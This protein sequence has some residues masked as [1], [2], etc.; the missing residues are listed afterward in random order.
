MN[1]PKLNVAIL[2]G[3]RSSEHDISRLSAAAVI[4]ALDPERYSAVPV[5]IERSGDWRLTS[6]EKLALPAGRPQERFEDE[7][8]SESARARKAAAAGGDMR[9]R[10]EG[11]RICHRRRAPPHSRRIQ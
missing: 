9:L 11:C 6:K 1:E 10:A 5:L 4:D 3:G 8:S 7:D 2:A